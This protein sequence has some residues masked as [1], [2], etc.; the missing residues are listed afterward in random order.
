MKLSTTHSVDTAG[1]PTVRHAAWGWEE[2]DGWHVLLP[3]TGIE[4]M[5]VEGMGTSV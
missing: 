4:N 1:R 3:E 2:H 5:G